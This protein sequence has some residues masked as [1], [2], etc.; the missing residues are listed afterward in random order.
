MGV[1][2]HYDYI[3]HSLHCIIIYDMCFKLAVTLL[4]FLLPKLFPTVSQHLLR[5]SSCHSSQSSVDEE[6]GCVQTLDRCQSQEAPWTRKQ[7]RCRRIADKICGW[8]CVCVCV[9]VEGFRGDYHFLHVPALNWT[10]MLLLQA[11]QSP[12]SQI[13]AMQIWRQKLR[14]HEMSRSTSPMCQLN[15]ASVR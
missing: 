5:C 8:W 7:P 13:A 2:C 3:A 1:W 14:G 6:V 9:C 12:S 11:R 4:F 15:S 10:A